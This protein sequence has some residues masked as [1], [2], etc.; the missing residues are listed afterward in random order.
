MS[1]KYSHIHADID[2]DGRLCLFDDR[3]YKVKRVRS[4][5]VYA[6]FDGISTAN[7][8]LI[9]TSKSDKTGMCRAKVK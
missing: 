3:G 1:A 8:D 7:I 5:I 9:L 2:D 4:L 6:S